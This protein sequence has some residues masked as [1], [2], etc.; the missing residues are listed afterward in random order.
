MCCPPFGCDGRDLDSFPPG[1]LTISSISSLSSQAS[2]IDNED[3]IVRNETHC[4]GLLFLDNLRGHTRSGAQ[5]FVFSDENG[6]TCVVEKA[7]LVS[8]DICLF[9]IESTEKRI[10]NF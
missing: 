4:D 6:E 5:L 8:P 10:R 1:N 9:P 2:S 3:V 7:M